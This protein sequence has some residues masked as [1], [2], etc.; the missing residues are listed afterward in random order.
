MSITDTIG[1]VAAT[2]PTVG[3][4]V[5]SEL[6][7]SALLAGMQTGDNSLGVLLGAVNAQAQEVNTMLSQVTPNLGQHVNFRA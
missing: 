5:A 3:V 4:A 7:K 2:N 6:T 1:Q